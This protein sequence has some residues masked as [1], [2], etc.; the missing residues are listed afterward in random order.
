[1]SRIK[2][3]A[4]VVTKNEEDKIADCL[5]SLSFVD[6]I[7]VVDSG[8]DDQTVEIAKAKGGKVI[9][10]KWDGYIEQKNFALQNVT[11]DW[12]L[13][14]D[15]DERV[16]AQLRDEILKAL[17]NPKADGYDIPR[18]AYY[19]NRWIRHCGWYPARK[20]R[21]FK[22]GKGRW[23]GENP[24]DK[25]F[26]KGKCENLKGDIYHLSFDDISDH[27]NTIQNF[28]EIGADEKLA[29]G[30]KGVWFSIA[31]RPPATFIKMYFLNLGFLDGAPGFIV[32]A[33]SS[34]HVFCKYIKMWEKIRPGYY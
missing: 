18:R 31:L 25:V 7:V 22:R 9:Y 19:I 5:D 2:L 34:Y 15:A 13:N 26:I 8:S 6:E 10:H 24:H 32:S 27:I 28:T 3:S 12:V 20:M 23:G 29:K 11:G 4:T 14:L 33:L 1:M 21:L 16:S 17:Q 30:K